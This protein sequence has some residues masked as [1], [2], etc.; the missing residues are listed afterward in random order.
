[1]QNSINKQKK[2]AKDAVNISRNKKSDLA[3]EF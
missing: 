3:K 2:E 1:M